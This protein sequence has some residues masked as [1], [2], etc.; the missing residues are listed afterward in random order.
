MSIKVLEI[1]DLETFINVVESSSLADTS[2]E[3]NV[4]QSTITKRINQLEEKVQGELF[5]RRSRPL[6]LTQL[7]EKVYLRRVIFLDNLKSWKVY[8][9][10]KLDCLRKK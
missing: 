9:N 10:R 2:K 4:N 5:N 3:L 1:K 7:G 8:M 6:R